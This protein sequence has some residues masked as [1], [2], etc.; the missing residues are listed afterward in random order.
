MDIFLETFNL[1]RLNNQELENLNT[2]ITNREM[3]S[4]TKNLLTKNIPGPEVSMVN[5]IKYLK[6]N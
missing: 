1:L 6:D 4:V 5:S 3:E 2:S